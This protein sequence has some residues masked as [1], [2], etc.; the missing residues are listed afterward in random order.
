MTCPD[1]TSEDCL[2]LNIFTPAH[3]DPSQP[4]PVMVFLPGGRFEQGSS[5][6][7]LYDGSLIT[8]RS[9][10]ILVTANYRLGALGWLATSNGLG[11]NFGLEDQRTAMRFIQKIIPSFGGDPNLITLFGQSAGATSTATHLTSPR[12]KGLFQRAIIHSGPLSLPNKPLSDATWL[13]DQ[14]SQSV[15]CQP[16][17]LNCLRQVSVDKIVD[18]QKEADHIFNLGKPLESGMPWVPVIDTSKDDVIG[19]PLALL[20]QGNFHKMPVIVGSVWQDCLPFIYMGFKTY[21]SDLEYSVI[22][23]AVFPQIF[24]EVMNMYPPTPLVGDKRPWLGVV[25]TDYIFGCPARYVAENVAN[26]L[27]GTGNNA[28]LYNF[29]QSLSYD[30]WGPNYTFCVGKVCHGVELPYLFDS[31]RGAG[32]HTTED[33]EILSA[34]FGALW[35]NFARTGDPNRGPQQTHTAYWPPYNT[36]NRPNIE[37]SAPHAII[38]NSYRAFHCNWWDS[39]GY[40]WGWGNNAINSEGSSSYGRGG[41]A[42]GAQ[43]LLDVASKRKQH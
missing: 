11:G 6:S 7:V 14:F 42:I 21:M 35:T 12:S 27:A 28:Y 33:E 8:N 39:K 37:M 38:H 41:E 36:N 22:V 10:V 3:M 2:T 5:G 31:A 25:G 26:A 43:R 23:L 4:A 9:G 30:G 32:F 18:M 17:D 16:S 19:Q 13:G 24:Q 34:Y 15:G 20:G 1:T 40:N 29:N